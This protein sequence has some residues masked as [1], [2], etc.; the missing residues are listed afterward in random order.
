MFS[1]KVAGFLVAAALVGA[2]ICQDEACVSRRPLIL[3]HD[4]NYDDILVLLA[5]LQRSDLELKAV[6][7]TPA[8]CELDAAVEVTAK[9]L[10][11]LNR[12]HVPVLPGRFPAKYNEFPKVWRELATEML[13]VADIY[14][15][16]LTESYGQREAAHEWLEMY[17]EAADTATDFVLTGPA[18]NLNWALQRA[19]QLASKV[20]RV[21]WM[22][23]AV[24]V[25]GNICDSDDDKAQDSDGSAEWNAFW[26]P[27]GTSELLSL[28]LDLWL[29]PLDATNAVP[30]KKDF[31]QR[32]DPTKQVA[33]TAQQIWAQS[34]F[35]KSNAVYYMWDTLTM[36]LYLQPSFC[37]WEQMPLQGHISGREQGRISRLENTDFDSTQKLV[38]VA[39]VTDVP[40]FVEFLLS[41]FNH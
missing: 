1:A 29:V 3:D 41:L 16:E 35:Q 33:R 13:Q 31:I 40:A 21:F 38:N 9:V 32:L 37:S 30:V 5:L 18:T 4:G 22:A 12:S 27:L 24:D 14:L 10:V 7:V 23:G 11:M 34:K 39:K 28:G 17:L 20:G 6:M 26:D 2:E 8:D 25:D 15:Q 19:P 36:G